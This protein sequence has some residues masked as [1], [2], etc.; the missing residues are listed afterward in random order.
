VRFARRCLLLA[1]AAAFLVAPAGA[2]AATPTLGLTATD[3]ELGLPVHATATL[4]EGAN[5]TGTILFSAFAPADTTC[6]GGSVFSDTVPVAGNDEYS[7]GNFTPVAAGTY[8]WSAVYSGDG[9]NDIVSSNCSAASAVAVATTS[10]STTA[11]SATVGSAISDTATISG[12]QSPTGQVEFKVFGPEDS[13]CTGTPTFEDSVAV[14]GNG[15]YPSA[16]FTPTAAGAYRWTASYSGDANNAPATSPCNA[17]NETS[18]VAKASPALATTATSATVGSAISD[19]GNLTGGVGATGQITFKAFGPN[20]A[21]CAGAAAFET[22]VSVSGNGSYGSGGFAAPAAGAYRWT[23]SYSGDADNN[24]ATSSCNAVNETSTV[25][26]ASPG[27]A[28]IAGNATIGSTI[29]DSATLSTGFS[30][31]GQITFKAF[32]PNDATCANP[33]GFEVSVSV[34]GNGVY[35]S[36]N[37]TP[38]AAGAYRWTASYSGDANNAAAV[39]AC[40]AANE[41]STVAKASPSLATTATSA[42]FGLPIADSATLSGAFGTPTGQIV[43]K[44]FGPGDATCANA[45]AFEANV[46]VNGNGVY[47]SGNFNNAQLGTYRW[48]ASYSGD[49]NNAAA[50]SACNAPNET[51]TVG[52]AFPALTTTA[53][54]ATIGSLI[55]D[56]ATLSG[57][58]SP[59]GQISFAAFGPAD[60]SCSGTPVFTASVAATGNGT[61]NSGSFTPAQ[62][63]N[64][65]W[66]ASYPGD[67]NNNAA[68][69]ACGA[70]N[71]TSV[72]SKSAPTL[73]SSASNATIGSS[74]ADIATFS[75]GSSHTGQVVFR[76][77]GPADATCSGA[78]VFAATVDVTPGNGTYASGAFTPS[79]VGT[80]RWTASYSGDAINVATTT[81]CNGVNSASAVAQAAPAIATKASAA[82]LPIG[83]AVRDT[84]TLAGGFQPRGTI[85][86]RLYGPGDANCSSQPVFADTVP[87]SG[88]AA[89]AS[90]GFVPA[91]PGQYFF[92]ASYSGDAGN[93]ATASLCNAA[94]AAVVVKKRTPS[95][96]AR[97]SLRGTN[98]VAARATIAAAAAPKGKILFQIFGPDNSRCAGKP[99]FSERVTVHGGGSY[100]P[101]VFRARARGVY[102]LTVAY[103]GDAWNKPARS[104]CNKSGQSIR[105]G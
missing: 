92:T 51:S 17:A 5:P 50:T 81:P 58:F 45:A 53:A 66:T 18:T 60:P 78:P 3:A 49:A 67:V 69:S 40:N 2:A 33:A 79:Q 11:T 15:S 20:D 44:A 54:S 68:N 8:R 96:S 4:G 86:F 102:R 83:T 34:S 74:I 84:A 9:E 14:S 99:I 61:Y 52:K 21:T 72:V 76:A 48:T 39:S 26:K 59:T 23:A 85:T 36:G 100:Q 43:F 29:V 90:G 55:S 105:V 13:T 63:G 64:Y 56:S 31:T 101:S 16:P 77:Y 46:A 57:G 94:G 103:A 65:K 30:P 70:A 22:T 6:A 42:P 47:G 80:Y 104:G 7:S 89:Y 10:I 87:A 97:V 95:L 19:S 82:S 27:L 73:S 71:E 1:A 91:Q 38:T 41:T 88:N 35:G 24:P 12:G 62:L 93:R 75:G 32:G 37:F 98:R 25:A 28:T